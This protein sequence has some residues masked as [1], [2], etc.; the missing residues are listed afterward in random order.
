MHWFVSHT[1][2][3]APGDVEATAITLRQFANETFAKGYARQIE[4]N[5]RAL[6]KAGTVDG[7]IVIG[8][9]KI[10][11]WLENRQV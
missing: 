5:P 8:P 9:H 6:L 10:R 11:A 3:P 1:L 7:T 4:P 2:L